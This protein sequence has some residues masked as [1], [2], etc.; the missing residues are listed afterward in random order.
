MQRRQFVSG[1][2]AGLVTGSLAGCGQQ[3]CADSSSAAQDQTRF[4]WKMVTTWPPNL[5]GLGVGANNLA[6]YI[7]NITGGRIKIKVYAGNELVPPLEV[8]DTVSRG[9]AEMGH[10]GAYYWKGKSEATQFFGAVPFGMNAQE[11][12][13]WLYYGGGL[14]LWRELYEPFNLVPFCIGHSGTQMGGWFNKELNSLEDIQGLKMRMPGLGGEVFKR[15]GGTPVLLPGSEIFTSLQTGNIDA[16]EWVGPYN[17]I[18]FAFQDVAKYY[19]YP[20]WHEPTACLEAIVNKDAYDALPEDLKAA[21]DVACKAA[22]TDMLADFTANN[23][24]SLKA[25]QDKGVDIRKFPD[26]ILE[27]F[28]TISSELLEEKAGQNAMFAKIY[29]SYRRFQDSVMKYH[30]ISEQAYYQARSS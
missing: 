17:D 30:A 11:M 18:A 27:R 26:E 4:E 21:V 13:G 5:P 20:G 1:L 8:F 29:E 12:N 15:A 22:A 6:K 3:D 14:E 16:T 2:G 28:R 25:L 19:Y 9:T 24:L 23:H 7:E 10:G